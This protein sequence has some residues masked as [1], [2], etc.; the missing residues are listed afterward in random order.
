MNDFCENRKVDCWEVGVQICGCADI[1]IAASTGVEAWKVPP[2]CPGSGCWAPICWGGFS[3]C[4]SFLLWDSS[5]ITCYKN[6]NSKRI[7]RGGKSA[8]GLNSVRVSLLSK[9]NCSA[10][11]VSAHMQ[12]STAHSH[13]VGSPECTV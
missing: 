4:S 6:L 8:R 11:V 12:D 2:P 1:F 9:L 5:R 10:L 13:S 7:R 3:S